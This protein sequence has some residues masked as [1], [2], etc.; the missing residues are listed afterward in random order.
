MWIPEVKKPR[1][2]SSSRR[3][4]KRN[5]VR[6]IG[7]R[8]RSRHIEFPDA[9]GLR[10]TA[11]RVRETLF[12]WLGQT[13]HGKRCLDLFAGSG[14]L[15]FEAL[16]RGAD[17]VVMVE[18]QRAVYASLQS[19]ATRFDASGLTVVHSDA[20][21][22]LRSCEDVFDIVFVDPP[23]EADVM[24]E[25]L[26][27]LPARLSKDALVY[28]ESGREISEAARGWNLLKHGRAGSAKFGL[29]VAPDKGET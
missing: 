16:S 5:Q 2:Q 22:F 19:N 23:F 11:D 8:W 15:G 27:L 1:G 28:I 7:G 14:A 17:L 3:P 4:G 20:R 9:Q 12:N 18:S 13:L 21:Q 6:I 25:I 10:P 24:S 26:L 29:L